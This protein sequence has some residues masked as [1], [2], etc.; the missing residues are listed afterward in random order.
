MANVI[1]DKDCRDRKIWTTIS[2]R[3]YL[4]ASDNAPT[5]GR[6]YHHL[7]IMARPH[8]VA[9]LFY[10][11]KALCVLIPFSVARDSIYTLFDPLWEREPQSNDAAFVRVHSAL[12]SSHHTDVTAQAATGHGKRPWRIS[13]PQPEAVSN[14]R[15]M[16]TRN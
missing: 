14:G 16:E 10:Y 11:T 12:Y 8:A 4:K 7:A 15:I 13:A 1:E 3:W 2:R 9:Q 5:T 6:L